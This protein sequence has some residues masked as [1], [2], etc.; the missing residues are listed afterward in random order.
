MAQAD[1]DKFDTVRGWLNGKKNYPQGL[2]L[3]KAYSTDQVKIRSLQQFENP[4]LLEQLMDELYDHFKQRLS[5]EEVEI[6]AVIDV[7]VKVTSAP[8]APTV[9]KEVKPAKTKPVAEP[10]AITPKAADLR[11]IEDIKKA[12]TQLY[13]ERAEFKSQLISLAYE[14][15]GTLKLALLEHEKLQRYELAK[16]IMAHMD[17]IDKYWTIQDYFEAHGTMPSGVRKRVAKVVVLTN[18]EALRQLMNVR[19]SITKT[20]KKIKDAAVMIPHLKGKPLEKLK[21]KMADWDGKLKALEAEKLELEK[22]TREQKD[23]K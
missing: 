10:K 17:Q 6:S 12:R 15:S 1:Q 3:L 18:A 14:S 13:K 2:M 11:K 9:V 4:R 7:E 8:S 5:G 21:L 19:S 22:Q 16:Q 20:N 23:N